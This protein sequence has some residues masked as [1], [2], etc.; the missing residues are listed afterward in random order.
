MPI[1][2]SREGLRPEPAQGRLF[3]DVDAAGGDPP[4]TA[5][6]PSVAGPTTSGR[7]PS[8]AW[9]AIVTATWRIGMAELGK[10]VAFSYRDDPEVPAFDDA[11]SIAV[12]DGDCALCSWG[13]RLI[14]RLDKEGVFRICPVGTP[15]G[16]ALVRHY[17][18]V[19]HDP[20]T[21]LLVEN[22]QAW[23]GMEA[24]I[25]IGNR[26]GGVGRL[27]LAMRVLPRPAREWLYR[28]IAR[29]RYRL[30]RSDMCAIPDPA[31]RRRLLT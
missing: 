2:P 1:Q 25:R 28:R 26:L 14:A 15:I 23:S 30:G 5:A 27:A 12:M 7:F 20:E 8:V 17:G 6:V 29:N 22:G 9:R 19:P 16:T 13:A 4:V 18:L 10:T 31:L 24:I 11:G 21:W 3:E